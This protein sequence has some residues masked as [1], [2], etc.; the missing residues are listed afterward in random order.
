MSKSI[1]KQGGPHKIRKTGSDNYTFNISI[2][3]DEQD[4][5]ARECPDSSC[6]PGYFK[7]KLGTG[8][9][10]KQTEVY[11][12]YCRQANA[13]TEFMS[14]EQ[15]RY[16]KDIVFQEAAKGIGQVMKDAL[17][18]GPSGRK[19]FGNGSISMSLEYQPGRL[20]QVRRPFEEEMQRSVVCPLCGL[21]HIVYGLAVWCPDCGKDIFMSHV[22]AEFEVVRTILGDVDRRRNELG[23]RV[24]ARDIENCLEDT[25]SIFEAVLKTMLIRYLHD[26]GKT[27]EEIQI[28]MGKKIRNG[29]Q[30]PDRASKI[31]KEH[32]QQDL[33]KHI[34]STENEF[35][36]STFEKR[37]P[38]THNLGVID[39]KYMERALI[40]ANEGREIYITK[41]E[42]LELIVLCLNLL[43]NLHCKLF[44]ENN[45]METT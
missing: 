33:F 24:A 1:F 26:H 36:K 11:C 13:P 7:I 12:P 41:Q 31:V 28:L 18:L 20:S 25:V 43:R 38:I 45:N 15:S 4:R 8:I 5:V 32:M 16:A 40:T 10:E 35:L 29:F 30:N 2:P 42:I 14:K 9:T 19:Q 6:S 21:D 17:G 22:D 37:H 44:P 34:T 23:S 39:K 3:D 27:K